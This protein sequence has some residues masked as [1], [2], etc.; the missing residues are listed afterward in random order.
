MCMQL[1]VTC[2]LILSLKFIIVADCF[3]S[4]F[5]EAAFNYQAGLTWQGQGFKS[6]Q[7]LHEKKKKK[8]HHPLVISSSTY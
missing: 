1:G 2:Q 5:K 7:L 6:Y 4:N 3:I 8:L